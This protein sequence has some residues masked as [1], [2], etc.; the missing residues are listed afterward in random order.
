[1]QQKRTSWKTQYQQIESASDFH[2]AVRQIFISD[3]FFKN[4]NCF[5]EVP[6]SAL[7]ETYGDNRHHIDWYIDELGTVIELHGEQH[8][9]MTNFGN[10]SY[11]KAEKAFNQMKYRDNQK[12]YAIID[13]GYEY[14]EINYKLKRK[15]S[16]EL[17]KEIIFQGSN[18]G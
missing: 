2:E 3:P 5:Q 11:E 14:R 12:K 1:L 7:V 8:Y 16:S 10:I 15:L 6:V 18:H 9:K 13:A 17:L 4:L